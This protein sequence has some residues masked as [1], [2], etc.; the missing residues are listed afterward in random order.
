MDCAYWRCCAS[1]ITIAMLLSGC[2]TVSLSSAIVRVAASLSVVP[3]L[4]VNM[5]HHLWVYDHNYLVLTR[6][7]VRL[8]R[9]V[10]EGD[11]RSSWLVLLHSAAV[12]IY[13]PLLDFLKANHAEIYAPCIL[14]TL[15]GYRCE[16]LQGVSGAVWYIFLQLVTSHRSPGRPLTASRKHQSHAQ[17]IKKAE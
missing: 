2:V 1:N 10:R 8:C 17:G 12:A 5:W 4:G 16:M 6:L 15:V 11:Y 9:D 13:P 7:S 14:S 3:S